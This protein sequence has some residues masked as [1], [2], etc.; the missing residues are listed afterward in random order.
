VNKSHTRARSI[1]HA[2]RVLLCYVVVL[3]A[4][5]AAYS[6]AFAAG[7]TGAAADFVICHS[8]DNNAPPAPHSRVPVAVPC[9]LCA[10]AASANALPPDP[11]AVVAPLSVAHRIQLL[12]IAIITSPPPSRAGL[13][14]APPLCLNG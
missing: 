14:R 7:Q 13:A 10:M 1:G 11:A 5:L 8:A 2:L 9:A 12:D 3:Q 6:A 4:F